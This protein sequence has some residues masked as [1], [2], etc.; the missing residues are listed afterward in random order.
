MTKR[1]SELGI[2]M[3]VK[4][5]WIKK[6]N[7]QRLQINLFFKI[8]PLEHRCWDWGSSDV[9][10]PE[11]CGGLILVTDLIVISDSRVTDLCAGN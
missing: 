6:S 9:E 11:L 3:S 1:F 2:S 8:D 4:F 10:K 5:T 7:L